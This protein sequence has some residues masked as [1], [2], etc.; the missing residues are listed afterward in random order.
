MSL[1]LFFHAFFPQSA[2]ILEIPRIL[3]PDGA[4]DISLGGQCIFSLIGQDY[5]SSSNDIIKASFHPMSNV[6]VVVLMRGSLLLMDISHP[7]NNDTQFYPL[8][9]NNHFTSYCFG[10]S[11]DW[12]KFTIFLLSNKKSEKAEIFYLCPIIPK[13]ISVPK[14]CV[15][16]LW[17][18]ID[19]RIIFEENNND[20]VDDDLGNQNEEYLE[21]ARQYITAAFGPRNELEKEEN[22]FGGGYYRNKSYII[23]GE[24][25]TVH[26]S[27]L[28]IEIE[29]LMS[30]IPSLQGPLYTKNTRKISNEYDNRE[31]TEYE[32]KNTPTDICVPNIRGASGAPILVVSYNNGD[33]DFFVIGNEV[34]IKS[35]KERENF[36]LRTNGFDSKDFCFCFF[37]AF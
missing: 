21:N 29:A 31:K 13:G 9:I 34:Q 16:D 6:H 33:I 18:W 36:D 30:S 15:R 2:G 4:I 22:N 10:P 26:N 32:R 28:Y 3:A 24:Y 1:I 12:M 14:D 5:L 19:E 35:R 37:V 11:V 8:G 27:S 23:A 7:N 20:E 25:Y 17:A